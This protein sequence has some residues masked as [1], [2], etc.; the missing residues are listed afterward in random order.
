MKYNLLEPH[1]IYPLVLLPDEIISFLRKDI[2]FSDLCKENGVIFPEMI[3]KAHSKRIEYLY[4]DFNKSKLEIVNHRSIQEINDL[5][6]ESRDQELEKYDF[7]FGTKRL[8]KKPIFHREVKV[9]SKI[10]YLDNFGVLA[11]FT[12]CAC[13]G[14][15][16]IGGY[17]IKPI[18]DFFNISFWSTYLTL[19]LTTSIS[20]FLYDVIKNKNEIIQYHLED[21]LEG[22][23]EER[24][25]KLSEYK[26]S[27]NALFKQANIEIEKERK[28]IK[29]LIESER[30]EIQKK[31]LKKRLTFNQLNIEPINNIRRGKT[32][33]FFLQYLYISF[34]SDVKIDVAPIM[35]K[36]FLPDFVIVCSE[37]GLYVD[38]EIDEPYAL[39]SGEIIHHDR[40][41]DCTRNQFFISHNWIVIRFSEK[42]IVQSP[43]ECVFFIKNILSAIGQKNNLIETNIKSES[44]WSY[45]E[46]NLMKFRDERSKYL[47]LLKI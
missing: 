27:V 23:D 25:L 1:T 32:E 40:S 24:L 13:I 30:E 8:P 10:D 9:R 46:V 42:Q 35:K 20:Y 11:F 43:D 15:I 2:S 34:K 28:R 36:A 47:S 38:I 3:E 18:S 37:L 41:K 39:E 16:T 45:E 19:V 14:Y 7:Y 12:V 29:D 17:F 5:T 4:M 44:L 31:I 26:K 21:V 33:L 22:S 6:H